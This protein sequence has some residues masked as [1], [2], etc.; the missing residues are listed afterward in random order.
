MKAV[1]VLIIQ[2]ENTTSI[3]VGAL[4]ELV[5]KTGIYAYVG[6]AQ[7]NF[8]QRIKRYLRKEKKLFWHID[9]LLNSDKTKIKKVL[10]K[11]GMKEEE[12][13]LANLI[14][15]KGKAMLKF[16]SSDCNCKSH[17]FFIRDYG[18]LKRNMKEITKNII[19]FKR[20][21]RRIRSS[22]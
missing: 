15:M 10:L 22:S 19:L 2:V 8:N 5:F 16:G 11:E 14:N 9:Y 1:Y 7:T 12:C 21:S 3:K 6:S 18:F 20:R 4:G 13:N 17:L